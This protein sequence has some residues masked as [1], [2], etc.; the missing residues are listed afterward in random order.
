MAE[1]AIRAHIDRSTLRRWMH[2]DHFRAQ[3]QHMRDEASSLAKAKLEALMLKSVMVLDDSLEAADEAL[4]LRAARIIVNA[5]LR[6]EESRDLRHRL[7]VLDDA[8][9]MVKRAR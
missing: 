5:A 6:S 3:L 2:D 4:R 8:L 9:I 1:G 7:D